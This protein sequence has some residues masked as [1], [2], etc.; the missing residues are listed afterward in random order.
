MSNDPRKFKTGIAV[1][2]SATVGGDNITTNSASQTLVN[3]TIDADSNTISNISNDE[4]KTGAAIDAAKIADGS[5][6]NAEFQYL[7]GVTSAIQDQLDDKIDLTE[8]GANNGVATLDAG[9]K[10]P[11]SQ[12]PSTVMEYK[13]TWNASTNT[14][15][16]ADGV[17]DPGDVYIVSVAGT[18]N[19]G[20]GS[21]SFAV[22]DWVIYNGS[23][24]QKSSASD[25]V[26]SVNGQ[27]GVVVLDSDD[28]AEGSTNLY[29]TDERA[30]D[31]VGTILTDSSKIDFTYNDATPEISAT[32][33]AGS[34]ANVD[35]NASA[36]IDATKIADGSVSNTE[37]QY[38]NSL[39]SNAQT[40]LDGKASTTLNNLGTVAFNANLVPDGNNT[41][42][43]GSGSNRLATGFAQSWVAYNQFQNVD[44]GGNAKGNLTTDTNLPSG[45]A[46]NYILKAESTNNLGVTTSNSSASTPA[47]RVETGNSSASSSGNI[48]LQTGTASTTRGD[49][50]LD[51]RQIDASSKKIVNL[52]DPT[53][54]QDAAT[55]AY[56]DTASS[57][58]A[59]LQLSNL[60]GVTAI[61]VDLRP[62]DD[63]SINLGF[64]NKR[65]W[66]IFVE[67]VQDNLDEMRASF[68]SDRT[69]LRISDENA[70]IDLEVGDGSGTGAI[71]A[72]AN[73]GIRFFDGTTANY[74]G[75][76]ASGL[77]A[78]TTFDLP[79]ADGT[80]GQFLQTDGSG[81][82]SFASVSTGSPGDI[83]QTS[84][85]L[86]DNQAS[87]ANVTGFAF[88]NASVRSFDALVS[89]SIDATSDV[90]ETFKLLGVQRGSDWSLSV[91]STGDDSGVAF[92]ITNAGQIQ[93]TSSSYAGFASGTIKFRAVVLNV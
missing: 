4:I 69:L 65:F 28:I 20:S 35:I 86:A 13:G 3:K 22:G 23:I 85:S 77:S 58:G 8:K 27:Q 75:L 81:Q 11:A 25:A 67:E 79:I 89:V 68:Y 39:T 15:T 76:R 70:S 18:Q 24:W 78:S 34:L 47:V 60:S 26:V 63:E 5:V 12:L 62:A 1:T 54:P 82:L 50:V 44:S 6:S 19:L 83:A 45:V 29:F 7:D 57:S 56:V 93:Y 40:Q 71:K 10:I 30:Q 49:I 74:V 80:S 51:G 37:F 42:N 36:A 31:A 14:P 53:N 59:N 52:A 43:I 48:V 21:I 17:G 88:A 46:A 33:V 2:G 91:E 16:L 66:Q 92:S 55:K 90:F 61:P 41:R 73:Q 64:S 87:P 9:G 72:K 32:I 38:I 84:F